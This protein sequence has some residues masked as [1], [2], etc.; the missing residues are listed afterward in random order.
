MGNMQ[1]LSQQEETRH[2]LANLN[3]AIDEARLVS[4]IMA[5]NDQLRGFR[6]QPEAF[7]N[8]SILQ[9][10]IDHCEDQLVVLRS[11]MDTVSI[12]LNSF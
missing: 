12:S 2:L 8:A 1:L 9:Q 6:H 3:L 5:L 10:E 11:S 7:E 4:K